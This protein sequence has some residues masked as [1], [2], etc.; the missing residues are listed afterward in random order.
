MV[1]VIK[2]KKKNTKRSIID[3][4]RIMETKIIVIIIIARV[5]CRYVYTLEHI[6]FRKVTTFL[7][8]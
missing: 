2:K 3:L 7:R 6:L 4:L 5:L 8:A 1:K